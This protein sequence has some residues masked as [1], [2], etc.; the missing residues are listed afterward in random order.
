MLFYRFY[1][2]NLN[3][4]YLIYKIIYKND[5]ITYMVEEKQGWSLH[6]NKFK[7]LFLFKNTQNLVYYVFKITHKTIYLQKEYCKKYYGMY[8]NVHIHIIKH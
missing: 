7:K 5:D 2:Q 3:I 8:T 6:K 4:Y 1:T